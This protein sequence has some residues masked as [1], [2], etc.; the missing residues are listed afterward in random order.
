MSSGSKAS[1]E[2]IAINNV[3]NEKV[4]S[5]ASVW[6]RPS[7]A[8]RVDQGLAISRCQHTYFVPKDQQSCRSHRHLWLVASRIRSAIIVEDMSHTIY[9]GRVVPAC[10]Y[11]LPIA[12]SAISLE[13]KTILGELTMPLDWTAACCSV[14]FAERA[15]GRWPKC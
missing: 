15:R 4:K 3:K 10:Q 12:S 5:R 1:L 2:R 14:A 9:T 7:A 6:V 13:G 11:D 8:L